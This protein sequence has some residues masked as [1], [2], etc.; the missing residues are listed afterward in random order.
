[1]AFVPLSDLLVQL[2]TEEPFYSGGPAHERSELV[3]V[4]LL[5][6]LQLR[7]VIDIIPIHDQ[8]YIDGGFIPNQKRLLPS[9]LD[10]FAQLTVPVHPPLLLLPTLA[11][12]VYYPV[13]ALYLV[14]V[15]A[16]VRGGEWIL[17]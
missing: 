10:H 7:P 14:V 13:D 2:V 9:I 8:L 16:V 15:Q 17:Q 3:V 11:D 1:M 4:Y 6:F 5:Y 12:V